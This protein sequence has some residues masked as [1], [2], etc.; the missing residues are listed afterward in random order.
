MRRQLE[1]EE[2]ERSAH[3]RGRR[4]R[5]RRLRREG[6][7]RR[8][9]DAGGEAERQDEVVRHGRAGGHV[10]EDERLV[11][12]LLPLRRREQAPPAAVPA[13]HH[14]RPR[15]RF[16]P[17]RTRHRGRRRRRRAASLLF[18]FAREMNGNEMEGTP[19][20]VV[21]RF[22]LVSGRALGTGRRA[23]I[24]IRHHAM[25]VSGTGGR[26]AIWLGLCS[27]L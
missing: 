7:G 5:R 3:G 23:S 14:L 19:I 25:A 27:E 1:E 9:V 6:E 18:S 24:I 26:R 20:L 4:T 10:L 21:S 17:A 13:Q 8:G 22:V 11:L 15:A 2:E 16:A 12:K